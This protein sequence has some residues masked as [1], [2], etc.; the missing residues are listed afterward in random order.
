MKR[1]FHEPNLY[2]Y[3]FYRHLENTIILTWKILILA[4]FS[5]ILD[6]DLGFQ[7][8]FSGKCTRFFWVANPSIKL[9]HTTFVGCSG[10]HWRK[11]RT[12]FAFRVLIIAV[13]SIGKN[14]IKLF[15]LVM[16]SSVST[17]VPGFKTPPYSREAENF[18]QW[19]LKHFDLF[20]KLA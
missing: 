12:T 5:M 2:S 9:I 17:F 15:V 6:S 7:N 20:L 10:A 3:I 16:N 1:K 13:R 14:R 18:K 11:L 8:R 4:S 19:K